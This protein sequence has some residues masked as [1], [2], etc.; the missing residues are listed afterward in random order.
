MGH[1]KALTMIWRGASD[2]RASHQSRAAAA[3]IP[4]VPCR[5]CGGSRLKLSY[6]RCDKATAL[7]D[8]A[9]RTTFILRCA[10]CEGFT[11]IEA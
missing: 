4:A 10:D 9:L 8:G 3:P 7:D 11:T 2:D 1:L 6:R 5:H